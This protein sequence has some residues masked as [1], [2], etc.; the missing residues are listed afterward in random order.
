MNSN[1]NDNSSESFNINNY[2]PSDNNRNNDLTYRSRDYDSHSNNSQ[3]LKELILSSNLY[4][5]NLCKLLEFGINKI[6]YGPFEF[7]VQFNA[8]FFIGI[9]REYYLKLYSERINFIVSNQIIYFYSHIQTKIQIITEINT[10]Y[11]SPDLVKIIDGH[12]KEFRANFDLVHLL[13]NLDLHNYANREAIKV[14]FKYDKNKKKN[15]DENRS[16]FINPFQELQADK[17]NFENEFNLDNEAIPGNIIIETDKEFK[18]CMDSNFA[19]LE[20]CA[21]PK[22]PHSIF[23]NYIFSISVDKLSYWTKRMSLQNPLDIFCNHY[24]CNF[25]SNKTSES[26]LT[27][28]NTEGVE[29]KFDNGFNYI[30]LFDPM[31]EKG[32]LFKKMIQFTLAKPELD[33]CKMINKKASVIYFYADKFEKYYFSKETDQDGNFTCATIIKSQEDKPKIKDIEECCLYIDHWEE[34][35]NYLSNI[36]TKDCI[37]MLI[38]ARKNKGM[39]NIKSV[40]NHKKNKKKGHKSNEDKKENKDENRSNENENKIKIKSS[41]NIKDLI[42]S[43]LIEPVV[44]YGMD[45]KGSESLIK[46]SENNNE[47]NVCEIGRGTNNNNMTDNLETRVKT[48]SKKEENGNVINPFAF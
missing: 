28:N 15:K 37:R 30:K 33:A 9:I 34:W 47:I 21:P 12:G 39:K 38:E 14:Y 5:K 36:L 24:I 40:S 7:G 11:I 26:F 29:F 45:K 46:I 43:D 31:M 8:K 10:R 18:F 6:T 22:V 42:N 1:I 2:F 27:Y 48:Q 44:I 16:N 4:H 13:R 32:N 17:Q 25:V 20:M 19:P 35:L 3:L 23:S 41:E